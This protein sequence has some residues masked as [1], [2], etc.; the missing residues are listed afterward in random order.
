MAG[1]WADLADKQFDKALA[2]DETHWKARYMKSIS[3]SHWPAFTGKS[4]EA[5]AQLQKLIEVQDSGPAEDHHAN[6]YLTLG[7][8]YLGQGKNE[9]ALA[10]WYK[11]LALFPGSKSL[12][13]Q[14]ASLEH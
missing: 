2:L 7:N 8:I 10:A 4:G 13:A 3:L 5:I 1:K 6:T 11:G 12:A 14:I 9:E